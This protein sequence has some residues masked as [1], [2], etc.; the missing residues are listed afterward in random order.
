MDLY[1]SIATLP[2]PIAITLPRAIASSLPTFRILAIN[3]VRSFVLVLSPKDG[4]RARDRSV[5]VLD[6]EHEHH[7]IEHEHETNPKDVGKDE[8]IAMGVD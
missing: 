5:R 3:I 7:F 2:T 1:V 4:T 8:A 6:C